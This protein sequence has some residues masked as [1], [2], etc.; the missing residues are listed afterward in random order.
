MNRITKPVVF[1]GGKKIKI[2][3]ATPEPEKIKVHTGI[4]ETQ[5]E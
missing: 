4:D 5:A 3:D 2:N 1:V